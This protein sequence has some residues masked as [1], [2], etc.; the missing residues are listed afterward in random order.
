MSG[1]GTIVELVQSA[2]FGRSRGAAFEQLAR[3]AAL[4]RAGA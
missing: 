2:T 1:P 3:L 4:V